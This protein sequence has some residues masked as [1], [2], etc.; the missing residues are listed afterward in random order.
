M[1]LYCFLDFREITFFLNFL[2]E[3]RWKYIHVE[4]YIWLSKIFIFVSK[5]SSLVFRDEKRATVW[6]ASKSVLLFRVGQEIRRT[7]AIFQKEKSTSGESSR[8]NCNSRRRGGERGKRRSRRGN[9]IVPKP[10]ITEELSPKRKLATT[11]SKNHFQTRV[12][13]TF[14]PLSLTV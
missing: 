3:R 10:S 14:L 1:F 13:A 12:R 11:R 4:Y 5:I 7:P 8:N 2:I 6:T 9:T